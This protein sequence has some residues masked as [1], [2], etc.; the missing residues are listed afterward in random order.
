[1]RIWAAFSGR[2]DQPVQTASKAQFLPPFDALQ[3]YHMG[4]EELF[5]LIPK[6][7]EPRPK[8]ANRE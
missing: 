7:I 1:L 8:H 5:S 2:L 6:A 4:S 3:M